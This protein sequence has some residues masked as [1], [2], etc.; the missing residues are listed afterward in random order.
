[1]LGGYPGT[2]ER[3]TQ[4]QK[5]EMHW[6][7]S[8]RDLERKEKRRLLTTETDSGIK[9]YFYI[10]DTD[11]DFWGAFNAFLEMSFKLLYYLN[12]KLEVWL[13]WITQDKS[14]LVARNPKLPKKQEKKKRPLHASESLIQ[15]HTIDA[16]NKGRFIGIGRVYM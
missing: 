10:V 3:P 13:S 16:A 6:T 12:L 5:V 9:N 8:D 4:T 2:F 1:M 14:R 7:D 11:Q 15:P